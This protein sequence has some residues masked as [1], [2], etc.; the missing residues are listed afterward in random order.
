MAGYVGIGGWRA[1]RYHVL[2]MISS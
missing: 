1:K 2:C